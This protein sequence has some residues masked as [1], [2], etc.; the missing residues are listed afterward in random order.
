MHR[1]ALFL[2]VVSVCQP[3]ETQLCPTSCV[4][5]RA[6]RGRLGGF[7]QSPST[8][9]RRAIITYLPTPPSKQNV[10]TIQAI[11]VRGGVADVSRKTWSKRRTMKFQPYHRIALV[12]LSSALAFLSGRLIVAAS[13]DPPKDCIAPFIADGDCDYRNNIE[14]CGELQPSRVKPVVSYRYAPCEIYSATIT[15]SVFT[16]IGKS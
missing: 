3:A 12:S 1:F 11:K 14:S 16:S 15:D 6:Y 10:L 5:T 9:R 13:G 7:G 2:V 4:G 8:R